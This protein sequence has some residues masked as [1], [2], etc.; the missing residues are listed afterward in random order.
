[1]NKQVPFLILVFILCLTSAVYSDTEDFYTEIASLFSTFEDDNTGL[2][3][4]PI[5]LIPM[6]GK[7]EGMGTAYTAVAWDTGF[8]E[9]NAAA[10][11]SLEDP[12]LALLHHNWIADSS[13]EGI[14][15]TFRLRDLGLGLGGKFLYLPFTHY[16]DY[17]DPVSSAYISESVI[18]ANVSYNF[19][20]NYY[21]QGIALGTNLKVGV[22]NVPSTLYASQAVGDQTVLGVMG[23]VG[24]L[25]RFNFLKFYDSNNRNFSIGASLKNVGYVNKEDPLPTMFSAGI[26]YAPLSPLTLAVDFNLPLSFDPDY[27]AASWYLASGLNL[28]FTSFFS[29]QLGMRIKENPMASLGIDLNLGAQSIIANY[30][31]DL[32]GR[33]SPLDKF[34]VEF[35]IK[36]GYKERLAARQQLLEI[37]SAGIDAMAAGDYEKAIPLLEQVLELDPK[38][39]P[40]QRNLDIARTYLESKRLIEEKA[41]ETE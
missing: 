41:L 39:V 12:E 37:F 31:L 34:S 7:L 33:V 14:I 17:G 36:L 28:A 24:L 35:K 30:N 6:G 20:S 23:D 2:T 32:S 29:M 27:P 22:R 40:A 8:M 13:I 16:Q 25:T 18:T 11:S 3:T 21:F 38:Y 5:L 19:F 26:A 1:M 15:Y 9:A 10:S 4:L